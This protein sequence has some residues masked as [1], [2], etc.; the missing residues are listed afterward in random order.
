[1][2]LTSTQVTAGSAATATFSGPGT[3]LSRQCDASYSKRVIVTAPVFFSP[4][5]TSVPGGRPDFFDLL[6]TDFIDLFS[7]Q[8][9]TTSGSD[10]ILPVEEMGQWLFP[11]RFSAP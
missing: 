1:M 9:T 7:A 8:V 11:G 3:W 4:I 10:T 5:W 2:P 6:E